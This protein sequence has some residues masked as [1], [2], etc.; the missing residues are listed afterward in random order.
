M[1]RGGA[2]ARV[3][4]EKRVSCNDTTQL[5]GILAVKIIFLN[6]SIAAIYLIPLV[7]SNQLSICPGVTTTNRGMILTLQSL[8]AIRVHSLVPPQNE[9]N[10]PLKTCGSGTAYSPLCPRGTC[11][12]RSKD[13]SQ[14]LAACFPV[15]AVLDRSL[16]TIGVSAFSSPPIG[17]SMVHIKSYI[18]YPTPL[19]FLAL[20]KFDG[21]HPALHS[22]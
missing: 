3:E 4:R 10:E 8:C 22:W 20:W 5:L 18:I 7:C 1:T 15:I 21:V 9:R 16:A 13:P 17:F 2:L 6:P 11:F 12:C 14:I 19:F